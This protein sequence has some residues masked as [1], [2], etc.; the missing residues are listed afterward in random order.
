MAP[1]RSF[2]LLEGAERELDHAI[3]YYDGLHFGR[4]FEFFERYED[5][6]R[7]LM[8]FPEMGSQVDDIRSRHIIRRYVFDGFDCDLITTVISR[9][10]VIIAIAGHA[11]EPGY[12]KARLKR[13]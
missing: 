4:G 11:Q 12:W 6:L 10:L 5:A 9:Q 3:D 7:D 1:T 13:L 8:K 2:R